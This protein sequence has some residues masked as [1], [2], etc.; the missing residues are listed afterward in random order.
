MPDLMIHIGSPNLNGENL[1]FPIIMI[2]PTLQ[3]PS[4][5]HGTK[6][7]IVGTLWSESIN[8]PAIN[9]LGVNA[10]TVNSNIIAAVKNLLL[11]KY[12]VTVGP[13]DKVSLMGGFVV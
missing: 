10:Q 8:F 12:E 6:I 7:G 1:N 3:W 2:I 13:E 5:S 11:N 4:F 9:I